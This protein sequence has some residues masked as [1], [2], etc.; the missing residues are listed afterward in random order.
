MQIPVYQRQVLPKGTATSSPRPRFVPVTS[1]AD[2]ERA[3]QAIVGAI[4]AY[5]EAEQNKTNAANHTWAVE[6]LGTESEYWATSEADRQLAFDPA[7]ADQSYT[8]GVLADFDARAADIE[9]R[10]PDQRTTDYLRRNLA[11]MRAEIAGRGSKF[12]AEIA[13]TKRKAAVEKLTNGLQARVF[14]GEASVADAD[15]ALVEGVAGLDLPGYVTTAVLEEQREHL[16]AAHYRGMIERDPRTARAELLSGESPWAARLT[17]GDRQTLA[18][19]AGVRIDEQDRTTLAGQEKAARLIG[20]AAGDTI[21][22][23]R[24]GLAE[25]LAVAREIKD[26]DTRK[27]AVEQVKLRHAETQAAT[28]D[29]ETN[30]ATEAWKVID[31]GGTIDNVPAF[32]L[33]NLNTADKHAI[34]T[35]Q[36]QRAEHKKPVTD[37]STY[38]RLMGLEPDKLVDEDLNRYRSVLADSEFKQL[39]GRQQSARDDKLV[40]RPGDPGTLSQQIKTAT[41]L[42]G[43]DDDDKRAGRFEAA[44]RRSIDDEQSRLGRDLTYGEREALVDRLSI[45]VTTSKGTIWDSEARLFELD[46]GQHYEIDADDFADQGPAISRATGI[47]LSELDKIRQSLERHGVPVTFDTLAELWAGRK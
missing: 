20:Q 40:D 32:V 28:R 7:E 15:T 27:A 31:A 19:S 45:E 47:P 36:R 8:D 39:V 37:W 4:G 35:Y 10:A 2:V 18:N 43:I 38:S 34:E 44:A 21:Y 6:A 12:E 14:S 3:G 13:G 1:A 42:L 33:G 25:M 26:P 24:A 9:A 5:G 22:D 29:R 16:A 30:A 11:S 23:P 17:P 46:D 41:V